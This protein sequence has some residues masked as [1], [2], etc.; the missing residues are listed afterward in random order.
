MKEYSLDI[1]SEIS[2]IPIVIGKI[3]NILNLHDKKKI[4]S[5]ELCIQEALSNAIRHG[6]ANDIQRHV[7]T[8]YYILDN[9]LHV[10]VED[11]GVGIPLDNSKRSLD[12]ITK[13]SLFDESGRGIMLMKH[14]C[15]EIKFDKNRV[16]LVLSL[17][18]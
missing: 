6:N 14:F 10:I 17:K 9:F 1:N 16:E 15:H 13:E 4:N 18:E 8:N 12:D 11:E 5:I 7:K 3:K 2:Q